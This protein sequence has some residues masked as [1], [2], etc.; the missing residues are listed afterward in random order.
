MSIKGIIDSTAST[1]E[2]EEAWQEIE[3]RQSQNSQ[4]APENKIITQKKE[5]NED[6]R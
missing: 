3:R 1:P 4:P 6:Q 5:N 2:E